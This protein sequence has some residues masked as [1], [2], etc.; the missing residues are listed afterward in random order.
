MWE[1]DG[2]VSSLDIGNLQRQRQIETTKINIKI[3]RD[4]D[5]NGDRQMI[6][7]YIDRFIDRQSFKKQRRHT[8]ILS[9]NF[10][11]FNPSI[12]GS[13]TQPIGN[14]TLSQLQ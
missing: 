7:R 10:A 6:G 1:R 11:N 8:K 12:A 4:R 9:E 14:F 5:R 2:Q 3:G 13:S